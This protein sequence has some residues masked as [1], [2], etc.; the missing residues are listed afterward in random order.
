[1]RFGIC[2][3]VFTIYYLVFTGS[4]I[5]P[6][7]E[8]NGNTVFVSW[9]LEKVWEMGIDF[10]FSAIDLYWS[11]NNGQILTMFELNHDFQLTRSDLV[12]DSVAS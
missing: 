7:P 1:M 3:L 2:Y 4:S 12:L 8:E 5:F 11:V 6:K 10:P 9:L